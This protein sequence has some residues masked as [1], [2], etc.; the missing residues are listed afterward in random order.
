M[1]IFLLGLFIFLG[2]HSISLPGDS[3]RNR[4]AERIGELP[5]KVLYSVFSIFGFAL[6][7]WGYGL[8]RDGSPEL[9]SPS[10]W[11]QHF[12]FVLF[13]PVFPLLI[14]AYFPGRIKS[15][16]RHPMLLATLL[17]A[18]GHLI[19][20]GS[21]IDV[22]LFGSFLVWAA[23]VLL[24]LQHRQTRPTPGAPSF[25]Y[26]DAIAIVIGLMLYFAFIF[27]L[28]QRLFGVSPI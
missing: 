24:S 21:L 1:I 4:L 22:I 5:W 8:A 10:Q 17:W 7:V 27:E 15:A 18:A 6:I 25:R 13:L 19:C 20:S 11:L 3:W 23:L 16:V 26:N 12:S 28:H 9:Y 14:A 2:I